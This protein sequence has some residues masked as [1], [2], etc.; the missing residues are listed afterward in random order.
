MALWDIDAVDVAS[1]FGAVAL[2]AAAPT[3]LAALPALILWGAQYGIRRGL[4][5]I[6][7]RDK[8]AENKTPVK[9]AQFLLPAPDS[10][11]EINT[12]VTIRQDKPI[13]V[14]VVNNVDDRL[15]L[16][17]ITR[18]IEYDGDP[19]ISAQITTTKGKKGAD[20]VNMLPVALKVMPRYIKHTVVPN[21]PTNTSV[22]IGYDALQK[23]WLWADF[24]INGDVVHALVA[25]QTGA[26]KDSV[27]R[28][29]FTMLTALNS[30]E[31]IQFVILDGKGEWMTT[32]LMQSKHMFVAPAGGVDLVKDERGKWVDAA[33]ER[34]EDNVGAIFEEI[35]RRNKV[36]AETNS[37]DIKSYYRKTG[38]KLPVIVV[39]ATDVGTNVEK[40]F[41]QLIRYLT[42]KGRSFGVKLIISMQTVSG[43]DTGW[44]NQLGLIMSGFQ[45]APAADTPTMGI[46]A[47]ALVYRPSQL[48]APTKPEHRGIFVVRQG[49]K[50]TLVKAPHI[51]DEDWEIF[52]ETALPKNGDDQEVNTLLESLLN[53]P[54]VKK[55]KQPVVDVP[56]KPATSKKVLTVEQA[57]QIVAL[58]RRG[59][60]K[61]EIMME[62]GFTSGPKYKETSP[63]VDMLINA[64]KRNHLEV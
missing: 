20:K 22:P 42:F 26:G 8:L 35:A 52:V 41:E 27:L 43:Q 1:G 45:Q 18:P 32:A 40:S 33:N 19:T 21:P 58:T 14:N 29:W 62:M 48:P 55:V 61:S 6:G 13:D 60:N 36:F 12:S 3:P 30:P 50:Q 47:T 25:G 57:Q 54:I 38:I 59:L 44:R 2:M 63:H 17:K 37:T 64:V 39:I 10:D 24:G 15:W 4:T 53:D 46:N 9:Y 56:V 11:E 23:E 31:D 51:S 7:T 5:T 49:N 28:L 16:Q 34:M